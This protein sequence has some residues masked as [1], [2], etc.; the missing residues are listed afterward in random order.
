LLKIYSNNV[1]KKISPSLAS[2]RSKR[3]PD[4]QTYI[5][6]FK[7]DPVL[8]TMQQATMNSFNQAETQKSYIQNNQQGSNSKKTTNNL[9]EQAHQR[10]LNQMNDKRET[11]HKKIKSF[12][13]SRA[14]TANKSG[15]TTYV[16]SAN[17]GNL[18]QAFSTVTNGVSAGTKPGYKENQDY[19][20]IR[21]IKKRINTEES[22]ARVTNT[23]SEYRN[24]VSEEN[25]EKILNNN[26]S[27]NEMKRNDNAV[28]KSYDFTKPQNKISA[29]DFLKKLQKHK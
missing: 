2:K 28:I 23:F 10:V 17:N 14:S 15:A 8:S 25:R 22:N 9:Y 4:Y 12:E 3:I 7:K 19:K 27:K 1:S 29:E 20:N 21:D 11:N 24:M 13:G 16:S 18:Q 26:R 5:N 6:D